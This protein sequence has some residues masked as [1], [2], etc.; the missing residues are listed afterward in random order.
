MNLSPVRD[1]A[2]DEEQGEASTIEM[3]RQVRTA[4]VKAANSLKEPT[5]KRNEFLTRE[6]RGTSHRMKPR[7]K[8][9]QIC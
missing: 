4:R 5:L 8:L 7:R 1:E 9:E 6:V 3:V 2:E